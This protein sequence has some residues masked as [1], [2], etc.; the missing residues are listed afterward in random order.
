MGF[1]QARFEKSC[2][3]TNKIREFGFTAFGVTY[4]HVRIPT[5]PTRLQN[6]KRG[7]DL[8]KRPRIRVYVDRVQR[9]KKARPI[10][11]EHSERIAA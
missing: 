7:N 6:G 2:L 9:E 10:V 4:F 11:E 8:D 5:D 1:G 3:V